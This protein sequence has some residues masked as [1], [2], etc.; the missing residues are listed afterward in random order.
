MIVNTKERKKSLAWIVYVLSCS[1]ESLYTG[2]TNNIENR[3]LA[4]NRGTGAKYTR[5]RRPVKLMGVSAMMK[6]S[7]AMSLELKIKKLPKEK[8][9]AALK[10]HITRRSS[11]SGEK[12]EIL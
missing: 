6:R 2:I 9:I 5:S 11:A 12:A 7:A 8:K 10:T 4:H 3:L 1:D